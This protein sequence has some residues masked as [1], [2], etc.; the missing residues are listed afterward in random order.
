MMSDCKSL[1]IEIEERNETTTAKWT[2]LSGNLMNNYQEDYKKSFYFKNPR[3]LKY[4]Q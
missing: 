2:N 1:S 3:F 4:I